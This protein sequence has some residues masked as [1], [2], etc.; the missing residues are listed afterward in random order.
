VKAKALA[1]DISPMSRV[2]LGAADVGSSAWLGVSEPIEANLLALWPEDGEMPLLMVSLDLLYPGRVLRKVAEKAAPQLDSDHIF[3]A[4][5]HTHRA[6]M[7][8]DTKP[9]LG[10]PDDIYM[11]WLADKL[12]SAIVKVL[13]PVGAEPCQ[14][15]AGKATAGHSINRRLKKRFFMARRPLINAYMNAP[16]K[17]GPTDETIIAAS[18][19]DVAGA[20]IAIL[21]NYACHP[22]GFPQLNT[23]AAHFPGV[24]RDALRT[25]GSNSEV[26]VLYFQ[27]FSG[28]T[29]PSASAKVHSFGRVIRRLLS[30]PL[31]ED[32]TPS[33]YQ[34][35]A[36]SLSRLVVSAAENGRQIASEP[37]TT[38]R[39][40]INGS[41][42][43]ATLDEDVSFHGIEIGRELAI[44]AV[45][46]EAVVEY[47][48]IVRKM[49]DA[50]FTLCVGCIDH[51][52]GYIPTTK[53]IEEGGYEAGNFCRSFGLT[54]VNPQIQESVV[55][56]FRLIVNGGRHRDA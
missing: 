11:D 8:D 13:E 3:L 36:E 22:V 38:S 10:S 40:E 7:T 31:F 18:I 46:G 23:V 49:S 27:G 20:P 39:V 50:E 17:L 53:I 35:W 37:L 43:A 29:R 42:F 54:S 9:L 28:N 15:M 51:T 14:I 56:G 33:A 45:S 6:P 47:T 2:E 16:N 1:I 19:R 41:E 32:M 26:P 5:T 21:W 44:A 55:D 12:A 4:A 25:S 34:L 30:G 24:V 52:F 48:S